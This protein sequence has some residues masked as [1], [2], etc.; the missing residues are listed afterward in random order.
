MKEGVIIVT[1]KKTGKPKKQKTNKVIIPDAATKNRFAEELATKPNRIDRFVLLLQ[2]SVT[3]DDTIRRIVGDIAEIAIKKLNVIAFPETLDTVNFSGAVESWLTNIRT[4]PL[5]SAD[6]N[7]LFLLIHFGWQ[8]QLLHHDTILNLIASAISNHSKI[9]TSQTQTVVS[10]PTPVEI[11]LTV[12]P[13]VPILATL[14]AHFNDSQAKIDQLNAQNQSQAERIERLT[15]KRDSLNASITHL[16][17]EITTIQEEKATADNRIAELE[18]EIVRIHN[19]YQHK[20]FQLQGRIRGTLQGQL[21]RWL[22]TALDAS[23]AEPPRS[24]VIQERLEDTLKLIEKEIQWLQPS[25]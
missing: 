9:Q 4:R 21:T 19:G 12:E 16:E 24:K 22:E 6:L 20:L 14:L 18:E 13:S 17:N 23:R 15:S 11:L 10:G 7:T 8:R 3:Y 2:A 25:D 1:D 5:K